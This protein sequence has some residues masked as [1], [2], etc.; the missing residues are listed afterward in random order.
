MVSTKQTAVAMEEQRSKRPYRQR[1]RAESAARTR[2]QILEAARQAL[3]TPP[4]HSV[5]VAEIAEMAGVVRST[6]Y[7]VFG[8]REGLLRAVADDLLARGGFDRLQRASWHPDALVRAGSRWRPACRRHLGWRPARMPWPRRSCH[9]ASVDPRRRRRGSPPERGPPSGHAQPG[10][11]T[12]RAGYLHSG[13]DHEEAVD[14]LWVLT[15][16]ETFAQLYTGRGLEQPTVSRRLVTMAVRTLCKQDGGPDP[17]VKS[18]P[19][20]QVRTLGSSPD[21]WVKSGP[22][23]KRAVVAGR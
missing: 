9:L 16:P 2:Q 17:W 12:R 21:P 5:T 10:K 6:I 11:A 20:G 23:V 13:L 1:L 4:L 14:I 3:T 19:L 15:N 8:A 18:G 22:E 7:T